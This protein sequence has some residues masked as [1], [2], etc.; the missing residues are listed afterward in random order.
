MRERGGDHVLRLGDFG[1]VRPEHP[2][3]CLQYPADCWPI[4]FEGNARKRRMHERA[5]PRP[6]RSGRSPAIHLVDGEGWT[7]G[8]RRR[9]L[10]NRYCDRARHL[11][12]PDR[13]S[14]PRLPGG[15]RLGPALR[16]L[17]TLRNEHLLSPRVD[18]DLA[19]E[20]QRCRIPP[21]DP[22]RTGLGYVKAR[23]N[24]VLEGAFRRTIQD[25]DMALSGRA[26]RWLLGL[27]RRSDP[28]IDDRIEHVQP[29]LLGA[30]ADRRNDEQIARAGRGDVG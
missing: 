26:G 22:M 13:L 27:A 5:E 4:G 9:S 3:L 10:S 29:T 12:P 6:G 14:S 19:L 28:R 15:V 7:W 20:F 17:R 1:S 16:V 2:G 18:V 21:D 30:V 11:S 23:C 24:G 8:C 25:G